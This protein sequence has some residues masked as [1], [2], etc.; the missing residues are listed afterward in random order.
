MLRWFCWALGKKN[1]YLEI[2]PQVFYFLLASY[3]T[4]TIAVTLKWYILESNLQTK[5][6]RQKEVCRENIST[7]F[8]FFFFF[9]EFGWRRKF[10]NNYGAQTFCLLCHGERILKATVLNRWIFNHLEVKIPLFFLNQT[11]VVCFNGAVGWLQLFRALFP[12]AY[13]PYIFE[14]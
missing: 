4:L 3:C 5:W 13:F 11:V 9:P 6:W 1:T 2:N 12:N 10:T 14:F 8:C 7:W